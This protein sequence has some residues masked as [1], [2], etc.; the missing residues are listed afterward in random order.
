ML[1]GIAALAVTAVLALST[2][3]QAQVLELANGGEPETLD[4]HRYNLR[5]EET[6]LNDLFLGLTTFNAAGEI[7]P[8]CA[9]RWQT[10]EDGLTWTFHLR[11]GLRWSDGQALT[12]H[13]FVYAFRRLQ[14][15]ETAASLAYFMDMVDNATE[16]NSGRAPIDAL[17]VA[18][19]DDRTFVITLARPYPYLLERL[20]YPT[21]Y[22]VPRHA[23]AAH[24]DDWV[25]PEHWVS[26]GAYA[27]AD[28][29]PQA[30][31]TM[32]T[33]P[34]FYAPAAIATVRYHPVVNEQSAY[35]RF[36]NKELNAV[37]AF[38]AG[39]LD[40]VRERYPDSLRL[41]PLLSM[42]YLVFNTAAAPFDDA[43]VRSALSLAIDQ[44]ILTDKVLRTGARPAYSFAPE[45]LAGYNPAMLPH[46]DTPY[47]NAWRGPAPCSP[48]PD[49]RKDRRWRLPYATQRASRARR[50]TWRSRACGNRSAS[51]RGCIKRSCEPTFRTCGR[52]ISTSRGPPG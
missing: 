49:S 21:A 18:A 7:V 29:Q 36:R 4:P 41:S 17:G 2:H 35:N 32:T 40:T 28:W 52:V 31:I 44:R 51:I 11:A 12:A 3:A 33:N 37:G 9:E 45:L 1:T 6:L 20:L 38:P 46:R 8:G 48:R 19:P 22:P 26:N 43:R 39:E 14:D 10:S 5:L 23:I 24:G 50:S 34:H 16:I 30:H 15:P 27:L 42:A 25:K 47:P 13:D